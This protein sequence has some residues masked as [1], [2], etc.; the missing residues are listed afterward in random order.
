M[1]V[2]GSGVLWMGL[3]IQGLEVV[4]LLGC[5][6]NALEESVGEVSSASTQGTHV[7]R[8][9]R[10]MFDGA[11]AEGSCRVR[12]SAMNVSAKQAPDRF[13]RDQVYA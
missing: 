8:G 1:R 4:D 10:Q 13:V 3:G 12:Q 5:I 11:E 7:E 6:A 2:D 9:W